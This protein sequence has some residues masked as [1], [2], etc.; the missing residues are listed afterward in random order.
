MAL[1]GLAELFIGVRAERV[2]EPGSRPERRSAVQLRE[3]ADEERARAAEHR[4][5]AHELRAD[6]VG[7]NGHVA[8]RLHD[9][10]VPA[11]IGDRHADAFD[12]DAAAHEERADAD[13]AGDDGAARRAALDRAEAA[14]EWAHM[15]RERAEAL[16]AERHPDARA[17]T[18][19]AEAA[20]ERAR[21]EEQL[22]LAEQ[23]RG[24]ADGPQPAEADVARAEAEV[25]DTWARM[26]ATRTPRG[27]LR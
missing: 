26:R 12:H 1:G 8:D 4:A 13:E 20:A 2:D 23:A 5:A 21:A 22:A 6:A 19:L 25:Y 11:R 24:R 15:D 3:R 18:N 17:H 7:G 14:R 16:A 10:E 9:E 27:P